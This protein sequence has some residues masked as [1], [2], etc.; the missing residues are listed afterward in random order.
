MSKRPKFAHLEF[1]HGQEI[2]F[3]NGERRVIR[4]IVHVEQ[5]KWVHIVC[6]DE[7]GESETIVNPDR[8]LFVRIIREENEQNK[9]NG[10]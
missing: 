2:Y 6:D 10:S 5:G 3:D 9:T 4:G 1:P 8:I 7:H